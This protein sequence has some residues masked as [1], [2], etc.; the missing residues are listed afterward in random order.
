LSYLP[1]DAQLQQ[2]GCRLP[3]STRTVWKLLTRLGL[4]PADPA[5]RHQPEPQRAPL[6][7]VQVD[8]KDASTVLP[9]PSG[10]GKQQ[11]VVEV[12]NFIDAGTSVLLSAQVHEDYH[13]QTAS[14]GRHRFLT[15]LWLSHTV[16]L[17]PRSPLGRRL[18]RLGFSLGEALVFACHRRAGAPLPATAAAEECLY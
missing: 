6:E 16:V 1:R 13:A 12:C 10:E 9:D 3:R 8:F 5:H 2:R 11:H 15:R 7:E 14:L 18:Q 4:L 17:R